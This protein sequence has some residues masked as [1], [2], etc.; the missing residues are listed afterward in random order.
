MNVARAMKVT[1]FIAVD[2]VGRSVR[3]YNEVGERRVLWD[4]SCKCCESDESN[5]IHSS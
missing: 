3:L 5:D 4:E 2:H 1:I